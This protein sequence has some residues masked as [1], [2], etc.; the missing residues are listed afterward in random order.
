M[1]KRLVTRPVVAA[2]AA[3][4][5]LLLCAGVYRVSAADDGGAIT[6]TLHPGWNLIGWIH[7]ET[8]ASDVFAQVDELALIHDGDERL[9]R[10]SASDDPAALQSLQ[11]GRGYWFHINS[12]RPIEWSRPAE[13]STRRFHLET[14]EQ[15]VAWAGPSGRSISDMLLGLRDQ[16]TIAWRWLAADQRFVPWS[17]NPDLPALNIPAVDR[18]EAVRVNLVEGAEWLHPTGDLPRVQFPGGLHDEVHDDIRER[19]QADL[20]F[21]VE[22]YAAT[23]KIEIPADRVRLVVPTTSDA[24]A[25]LRG[26]ATRSASAW[27]ILPRTSGGVSQI[28]VPWYFWGYDDDPDN[29]P[30]TFTRGAIAHELFHVLQYE[31]AGSS[32]SCV[33][34]WLTEGTAIWAHIVST[35]RTWPE[36][37]DLHKSS[38]VLE[39]PVSHQ[40]FVPN[41][42]LGMLAVALLIERTDVHSIVDFW[43]QSVLQTTCGQGWQAAFSQAFGVTFDDFAAEFYERRR[44]SFGTIDV[45]LSEPNGQSMENFFLRVLGW[46]PL[47]SDDFGRVDHRVEV[48]PNGTLPLHL[49]RN[50]PGTT[51]PIRYT[52]FLGREHSY[53]RAQLLRDGTLLEI[54]SASYDDDITVP[55][56]EASSHR[57]DAE[58]PSGFCRHRFA[59]R[60]FGGYVVSRLTFVLVC[61]PD[62]GRCIHLQSNGEAGFREFVPFPSSYSI[63]IFDAG[64]GC[65][66]YVAKG[67][68]TE[69]RASATQFASSDGAP[70]L[71]VRLDSA[72][73]LC[74]PDSLKE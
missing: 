15:L 2:A 40:P 64:V 7:E 70:M 19:I 11:P 71:R 43:R 68:Y 49:M 1:R 4:A 57:L 63:Q 51:E 18:G 22:R 56:A 34:G 33:P 5:L 13:P 10:R 50:G 16:V 73:D 74:S 21:V 46:W 23:F 54:T 14:G 35:R 30:P 41:H 62:G 69:D 37:D 47:E 8:A 20:Q 59:V 25:R 44:S 27:A 6:T 48:P 17:P 52:L 60:L 9:V 28:V 67:G 66:A 32:Y 3:V 65:G 39:L 36:I 72:E 29:E 12:E 58:L 26:T 61:Q 38:G 24:V 45:R 31:F 53:C 42:D 55:P